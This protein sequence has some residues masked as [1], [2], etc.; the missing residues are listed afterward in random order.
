MS[1][2]W[3]IKIKKVSHWTKFLILL[4]LF[5]IL[6]I[7]SYYSFFKDRE[8]Y[9]NTILEMVRHSVPFKIDFKR[10]EILLF[11]FPGIR[12][13]E[14][15]ISDDRLKEIG[16]IAKLDLRIHWVSILKSKVEIRSILIEN[17]KI[18]ISNY[19]NLQNKIK[20]NQNKNTRG[21]IDIKQI[22]IN[23]FTLIFFL[24][25]SGKKHQIY[26]YK[27]ELDSTIFKSTVN[28]KYLGKLNNQS[29]NT[30]GKV[31]FANEV[32][33]YKNLRLDLQAELEEFSLDVV[34]YLLED[35]IF[36]EF[37]HSNVTGKFNIIKNDDDKI[38]LSLDSHFK[39]LGFKRGIPFI[40]LYISGKMYYSKK[41]KKIKIISSMLEW[42]G[43][44]KYSGSGSVNYYDNLIYQFDL[45]SAY[46]DFD[47][48]MFLI[49]LLT[50]KNSKNPYYFNATS[51]INL[52][53][54][55]FY[56]FGHF[57]SKGSFELKYKREVIEILKSNLLLYGGQVFIEGKVY[58]NAVN[59]YDCKVRMVDVDIEKL[60]NI[61]T[62]DKLFT[63]K[64]DSNYNFISSGSDGVSFF[65]NLVSN[66]YVKLKN[67]KL[68]G[69]ANILKP[70]AS[71]GKLMNVLGPKGDS[72][73][74]AILGSEF[75]AKNNRVYFK[76]I[77]MDGVGLDVR[78]KGYMGLNNE[79]DMRISVGF[80]GVLGKILYV[81][82]IYKG[83][84]PTNSA[85]VDP[86]WLGSVYLG[87]TFLAGP[88]GAT[89]GGI[90]GSAISDYIHSAWD[91][92]KSIW[93]SEEKE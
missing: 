62:K 78:G 30:F 7:S 47:S 33:D 91:N 74:F 77:K 38:F 54:N 69:Y 71:L 86:I 21:N 18:D 4:S 43:K 65:N 80:A 64:M 20:Q 17:G 85:Y 29:I 92:V 53:L 50:T 90:A 76:E 3:K 39:R 44:V 72:T 41:E 93:K 66:G 26:T 12:F 28:F 8:Y 60:M 5:L 19:A 11:P 42:P 88:A 83:I 34:K 82:V 58:L 84:I 55:N 63:G 10:S 22:Y 15:K 16:H 61:Y 37:R 79:I 48:S 24:A 46:S 56:A 52:N 13:E 23:N 73:A 51:F 1:F 45:T 2:T 87:M 36:A 75:K 40:E 27:S 49:Q 81:P 89:V 68:L 67:G 31:S 9:K 32:F 35:F 25:D 70:I 14:I 6:L 59:Q 57:F